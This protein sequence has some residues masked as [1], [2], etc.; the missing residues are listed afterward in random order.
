MMNRHPQTRSL[1]LKGLLGAAALIGFF[2]SPVAMAKDAVVSPL[3]SRGVDPLVVLNMTSLISSELD[4]MMVYDNV[5]Q[6][7]EMPSGMNSRCLASTSCLNGVA[8]ASDAQA[9]VAGAVAAVGT[10]KFDIYLVL[11]EDGVIKRKRDFSIPNIP[12]VIADSMGGFVKELVTGQTSVQAAA[13]DSMGDFDTMT[14]A[15]FFD[16]EED[17]DIDILGSGSPNTGDDYGGLS[18]FEDDFFEED[19]GEAE[20]RAEEA[21]AAER[22]A[23]EARAAEAARIAEDARIAERR[24][25]EDEAARAEKA[26][27]AALSTDDDDMDFEFGSPDPSDI[28]VEEVQF[29]SAVNA[30]QIEGDFQDEEADAYVDYEEELDEEELDEEPRRSS[31]QDADVDEPTTVRSRKAKAK[32]TPRERREP[33]VRRTNE[34]VSASAALTG[35]VGNS[36][37]QDLN[38]VTYGAEGGFVI[39]KGLSLVLGLEAYSVKREI[40]AELLEPGAPLARWNTILPLNAGLLYRFSSSSVQPYIGA[41]A[42]II[43]GYVKDAGGMATGIRARGGADFLLSDSFGLNLNLSAGYWS[44]SQ[45]ESVDEGFSTSAMVPQLS[46][47]TILLF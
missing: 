43:P 31:R 37:F 41:D 39:A 19:D 29:G 22:R 42:Q 45:F 38:F 14:E 5:D 21:Q 2:A 17:I 13:E 28:Q 44:G 16:D 26:R 25:A 35:R 47:G 9:L 11:F 20:R 34:M 3:V 27:I 18:D 32:P 1:R 4:F 12:S 46:T 7:E 33:R 15:D 36:R 30:I 23:E 6:L 10:K 8:R 24:R 40:P